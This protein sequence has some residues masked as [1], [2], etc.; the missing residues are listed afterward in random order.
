[1]EIRD[2]FIVGIF[3]YCDRWCE[4]CAFTSR[5]RLFAD[6]A[7]M[8]A[9]LDPNLKAIVEA[10]VLPQ[11]L[12]P[13]P[14]PWMEELIDEMNEV[15]SRPMSREEMERLRPK[16]AV[17]HEAIHLRAQMYCDQV[18]E[19]LQGRDALSIH[20]SG[21]P[22]AVVG[23]FHTLIPVKIHRALTG[24]ADDDPDER[25]WP[26]DHDGSAK[27]ALV[28]IDRSRAAW[29]EMRERGLAAIEDTAAF[30][31]DLVSLSE[32]LE[33]VFPSARAFVRPAF[34]EPD[35]VARLLGRGEP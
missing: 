21:D 32:D 22:R 5:C 25:D 31:A 10:P 6:S 24:L 12:P 28:G 34:D 15:A 9:S 23:W 35:E 30:V 18:H 29:L 3:N 20:E 1:M 14:P 4:T 2:G 26:A 7:E 17:E 13:A 11:D 27:V 19:W 16:M 8:E 33:R